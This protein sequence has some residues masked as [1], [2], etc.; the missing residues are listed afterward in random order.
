MNVPP[1]PGFWKE[2]A[3]ALTKIVEPF[4]KPLGVVSNAVSK[5][6][7]ILLKRKPRLYV[8]FHPTTSLWCLIPAGDE[9]IME[10]TFT[11]DFTH[12]D[13]DQTVLLIEAFLEGTKPKFHFDEPID[14]DPEELVTSECPISL[15]VTPV[16]GEEGKN[17]TGRV[18]FIDQLH[19]TY[20]TKKVE[21]KWAGGPAKQPGKSQ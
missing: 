8:N 3:G 15:M 13:P 1:Q 14:I 9:R 16:V 10:V 18:I 6:L 5:R 12:D 2:V 20:K 21:F 7:E 11:A 17:W 4:T 19:R